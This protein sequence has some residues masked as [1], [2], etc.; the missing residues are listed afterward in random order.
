MP[1]ISIQINFGFALVLYILVKIRFGVWI[2]SLSK[3]STIVAKMFI[4]NPANKII[5]TGLNCKKIHG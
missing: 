3:V 2:V 1:K 4:S 5:N